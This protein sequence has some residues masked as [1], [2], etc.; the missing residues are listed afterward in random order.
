MDNLNVDGDPKGN[1]TQ[2]RCTAGAYE[3]GSGPRQ[4]LSIPEVPVPREHST[5]AL[6]IKIKLCRNSQRGNSR[7][8]GYDP[9]DELKRVESWCR[10]IAKLGRARLNGETRIRV[11]LV[12]TISPPPKCQSHFETCQLSFFIPSAVFI[13]LSTSTTPCGTACSTVT[14]DSVAR[15]LAPGLGWRISNTWPLTLGLAGWFAAD[16]LWGHDGNE[17]MESMP[18]K[19]VPAD[20]CTRM[21]AR[22]QPRKPL[23][24]GFLHAARVRQLSSPQLRTS[25]TNSD[26]Q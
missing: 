16:S 14:V 10:C 6:T 24:A 19:P 3:F 22:Q 1:Q 17:Q 26:V 7:R 4:C 18:A 21:V 23:T 2:G 12:L 25:P 11:P 13:T 5:T 20:T 15:I 9:V 8:L